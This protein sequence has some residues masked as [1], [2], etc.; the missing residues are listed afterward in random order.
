MEP[1]PVD[2]ADKMQGNK[3]TMSHSSRT[4]QDYSTNHLMGAPVPIGYIGKAVR[5]TP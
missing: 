3:V 2:E 1:H 4:L 5:V